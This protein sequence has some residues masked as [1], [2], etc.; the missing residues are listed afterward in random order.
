M[1]V[2]AI[3]AVLVAA[4]VTSAQVVVPNGYD[5][6]PA[7]GTFAL[8]ATATAGRTYQFMLHSNQLTSLVGQNLNGLQFRLNETITANWPP[9]GVSF[10]QWDIFIG[11]GVDPAART[12]T[13]LNNYSGT[14]TQVRSGGLTFNA[15]DFSA[16][17]SPVKPFGPTIGFSNYLYTGGHLTIEMRFSAQ[18]GTTTVPTF[19]AVLAS[20]GAPW[21]VDFASIW[22]SNI[23]G[24]TG[25]N[26]NFLVTRL[27]TAVPEP[28]TMAALGFG[29]VA[30]LRRRRK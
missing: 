3:L 9:A 26:A 23:A 1:R 17:G 30:L 16:A 29:V 2:G 24:T 7:N 19:D 18:S 8:T 13:F 14:R 22:T 10:T 4:A 11:P 27:T 12:T 25:G 5:N 28:A 15:G 6:T 20:S 21:G